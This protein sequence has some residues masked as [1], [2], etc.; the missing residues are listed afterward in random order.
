M[1]NY[2]GEIR[3][4]AGNFSPQG[5]LFCQGQVVNISD[6]DVLYNLLGTTYGGNGQTTFALPDLRSRAAVGVGQGPGLSPYQLG[7]AIG[8]EGVP[9]TAAQL[10]VHQHPVQGGSVRAITGA[11]GQA[12]PSQAY[13]GDKAGAAY[14]SSAGTA[15]L[16]PDAVTGQTTPTGDSQLHSNLQP[17]LAINYIIATTGI[18]PSS[19]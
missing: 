10:P 9:L 14:Q 12:S 7:Q 18:Y 17:L 11:A 3:I 8:Q 19:Q 5:W 16:A 6:Y 1:D 15:T 13:F 4:F 2:I